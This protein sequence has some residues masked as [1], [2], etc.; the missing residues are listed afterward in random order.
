[1]L[2]QYKSIEVALMLSM[3][4]VLYN[5]I[6]L[7]STLFVYLSDKIAG[8][9]GKFFLLSIAFLILYLPAAIR[10]NI[11]SDYLSYKDIFYT[12]ASSSAVK[13]ETGFVLLNKIVYFFGF[14]YETLVA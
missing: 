9:Y 12:I 2:N 10:F 6:L 3:T 4:F 8:K 14:G 11:G 13:Y 5:S 1:M 7:L